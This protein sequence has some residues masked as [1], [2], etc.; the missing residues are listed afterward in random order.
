MRRIASA[1]GSLHDIAL[2][3]IALHDIALDVVHEIQI[4]AAMHV[5]AFVAG[6]CM[7]ADV[8]PADLLEPFEDRDL[9]AAR[10][11]EPRGE[12]P[13]NRP[14]AIDANLHVDL[15]RSGWNQ[16]LNF[17]ASASAFLASRPMSDPTATNR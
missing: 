2:H 13:A 3:E 10:G 9:V 5:P 12:M 4:E 17:F 15:V 6:A 1:P 7:S 11:D 16:A 8:F 14:R